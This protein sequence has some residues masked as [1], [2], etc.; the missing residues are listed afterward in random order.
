MQATPAE[1]AA[2]TKAN[3]DSV[4][5]LQVE[6]DKFENDQKAREE[7]VQTKF[8]EDFGAK[9]KAF[10][11][12]ADSNLIGSANAGIAFESKTKQI[13]ELQEEAKAAQVKALEDSTAAFKKETGGL[14]TNKAQFETD[15]KEKQAAYL[16]QSQSTQADRMYQAE[17]F[18]LKADEEFATRK[19]KIQDFTTKWNEDATAIGASY[20]AHKESQIQKYD[21]SLA[22]LEA[23][24]EAQSGFEGDLA[25]KDAELKVAIKKLFDNPAGSGENL[26]TDGGLKQFQDVADAKF[27]D[28]QKHL[29]KEAATVT[30][31]GRKLGG[32]LAAVGDTASKGSMSASASSAGVASTIVLKMV[33]SGNDAAS[34]AASQFAVKAASLGVKMEEVADAQGSLEKQVDSFQA[35]NTATIRAREDLM[36]AFGEKM[37]RLQ[38]EMMNKGVS[39]ITQG[40]EHLEGVTEGSYNTLN[41]RI[42]EKGG[43]IQQEGQNDISQASST[44]NLQESVVKG[45]TDGMRSELDSAQE[46]MATAQ[47]N[48]GTAMTMKAKLGQL[49]KKVQALASAAKKDSSV[50]L[51][52]ASSEEQTKLGEVTQ[53]EG[54]NTNSVS[55]TLGNIKAQL[56]A[57]QDE[58]IEKIGEEANEALTRVEEIEKAGKEG[59]ADMSVKMTAAT[60]EMTEIESVLAEMTDVIATLPA[61]VNAYAG[62]AATKAADLK[63][64]IGTLKTRLKNA[65]IDSWSMFQ[66]SASAQIAVLD[67]TLSTEMLAQTDRLQTQVTNIQAEVKENA[68]VTAARRAAKALEMSQFKNG[69]LQ[70]SID[71]L[72]EA[73][74]N[75]SAQQAAAG[76]VIDGAN[77][78]LT[79]AQSEISAAR[80][81]ILTATKGKGEELTTTAAAATHELIEEYKADVGEMAQH[82]HQEGGTLEERYKAERESYRTGATDTFAA[83]NSSITSADAKVNG[84]SELVNGD[85]VSTALNAANQAVNEENDIA[86][87]LEG[88]E[89]AIRGSGS[90]LQSKLSSEVAAAGGLWS[91]LD[92][93]LQKEM[94]GGF[95]QAREDEADHLNHFNEQLGAGKTGLESTVNNLWRDLADQQSQSTTVGKKIDLSG[96][97]LGD[98][99]AREQGHLHDTIGRA[100]ND[101]AA[102]DMNARSSAGGFWDDVRSAGSDLAAQEGEE[103]HL[104]SEL[105]SGV[106]GVLAGVDPEIEANKRTAELAKLNSSMHGEENVVHEA[107]EAL[108]AQIELLIKNASQQGEDV[109]SKLTPMTAVIDKQ[110]N[111]TNAQMAASDAAVQKDVKHMDILL[112]ELKST[113]HQFETYVNQSESKLRGDYGQI[114]SVVE[115]AEKALTYGS[116]EALTGVISSLQTATD[117]DRRIQTIADDEL[118][119]QTKQWHDGIGQVMSELGMEI[120]MNKVNGAANAAFEAENAERAKMM[121]ATGAIDHFARAAA[122]LADKELRE[123]KRM[124]EAKIAEIMAMEGL[125]TEEKLAKI[126]ALK[127][128]AD[129]QQAK[130]IQK[131]KMLLTQANE[132]GLSIEDLRQK[133]ATT[134]MRAKASMGTL[135]RGEGLTRDQALAWGNEISISMASLKKKLSAARGNS[136][137]YVV[138]LQQASQALASF[139][140]MAPETSFVEVKSSVEVSAA[141]G[142]QKIES[143]IEKMGQERKQEDSVLNDD[144]ALIAQA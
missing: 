22:T 44:F 66:G 49:R 96:Q 51:G 95:D 78:N 45:D 47:S 91:Q 116:G 142:F 19:A 12:L 137:P 4:A 73:G 102:Q 29:Q 57:V 52:D 70:A 82:L 36:D 115:R 61:Q 80:D 109:G 75:I 90:D 126:K 88:E 103:G 94:R 112:N 136:G 124:T 79:T 130:L 58:I 108:K 83:V 93:N 50:M 59:S 76:V 16:A 46:D 27:A 18:G 40:S 32:S 105:E 132:E 104:S 77:T 131:S 138:L 28:Y 110:M 14:E 133:L 111:S 92:G 37:T 33:K 120:D 101:L 6:T 72:K 86:L 122:T 56:E 30:A 38:E 17:Q 53:L 3:A 25:S 20:S 141:A 134:L 39:K 63:I 127:A 121:A 1:N 24:S 113:E 98:A 84:L 10:N 42:T 129:R 9:K 123:L 2:I 55:A 67:Q 117:E 68:N 106:L 8:N 23:T 144:L 21:Q 128:N 15:A 97:M 81:L 87:K 41:A 31:L 114:Q 74:L 13:I 7:A 64:Q 139:Q 48:K 34:H 85:G 119:P 11:A 107:S 100:Q 71:W 89:A 60:K 140:K 43:K 143:E 135:G 65:A 99:L 5:R 125:S 54:L 26:K 69:R 118:V 35:Q 62:E